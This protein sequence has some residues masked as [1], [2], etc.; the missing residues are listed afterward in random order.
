MRWLR[1]MGRAFGA[2]LWL[3]ALLPILALGPAAVLDRGP[4]GS[5]R[6]TPFPAALAAFD[7]YV[8]V[9]VRN[10]LVVAALV[11]LA[12]RVIGVALARVSVRWRFWGR[13]PLTLLVC[14]GLAVHPAFGAIGLRWMLAAAGWTASQAQPIG[15]RD[16]WSALAGWV[17]WIWVA[18]ASSVPLV[19][20]VASASLRRIEPV[21]EDAA[22]L[23]GTAPGR[24]WRPLVWP[25]IRPDV[26]RVLGLVFGLTLLDPG[27]PL[28]LGLRR[29]LGAQIVAAA[30]AEREPG[31]L[32]RAVVLAVAGTLLALVASELLRWWG[33]TRPD[34]L[35]DAPDPT[36]RPGTAS[37]RRSLVLVIALVSAATLVWVPLLTLLAASLDTTGGASTAQSG[38]ALTAYF[39][40]ADNPLVWRIVRNSV[41]LGVAVVA[42]DL[43]LARALV[44][45]LGVRRGR[46]VAM[47][48]WPGAIPPLAIGIGALALPALVGMTADMLATHSG[49]ALPLAWLGAA[50]HQVS[51]ALDVDRTPGVL[52]LIGVAT[53]RLSLAAR[54]AVAQR[55]S[56]RASPIDA[57]VVLGATPGRARRK[58]AGRWLLGVSPAAAALTFALATTSPVPA[59]V[60]APTAETR[61]VGPTILALADDPDAGLAR[62]AALATLAVTVNL[63]A[64]ALAARGRFTLTRSWL[65]G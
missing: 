43:V 27:A 64:L 48:R 50:F 19:T 32:S 35:D 17:A 45:L 18:L 30:L 41:C 56:V 20:L 3:V 51:E 2:A 59:L 11:T 5:V 16:R 21:W 28:V 10:S 4:G 39:D 46:F 15:Q 31:Q 7:P 60:L 54:S 63:A 49:G 29:T 47:A 1:G 24:N 26:A 52:L 25:L 23:A 65:H 33:G 61:P 36:L 12:A 13:G 34:G 9:C 8:W 40:L 38:Q 22:R 42:F 6:A 62:A 37:W 55:R 14:M 57:A 53:A 58:L 44:G